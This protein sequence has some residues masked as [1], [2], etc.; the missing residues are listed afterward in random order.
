MASNTVFTL[1]FKCKSECL[2]R[3]FLESVVSTGPSSDPALVSHYAGY[4]VFTL[5]WSTKTYYFSEIREFLVYNKLLLK[6]R[7]VVSVAKNY[8]VEMLTS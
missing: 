5:K 6:S 8:R 7:K 4:I 3:V 1:F 2:V